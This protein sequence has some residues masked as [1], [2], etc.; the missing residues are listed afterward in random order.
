MKIY[1]VFW[2]IIA[3]SMIVFAAVMAIISTSISKNEAHHA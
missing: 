1:K 2:T 3:V